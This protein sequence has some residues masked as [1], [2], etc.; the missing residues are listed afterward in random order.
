MS[1]RERFRRW[2][3]QWRRKRAA[4][5]QEAAPL[6]EFVYLDEVS[7][8]SL[9][10]S[11]LGSVA[12]EFTATDS[13]S[14]TGELTGTTGVS[15]GL[16]KSAIKSRSEATQTQGTQ[17]LRKATVQATFKELYEYLESG[18]ALRPATEAPPDV[19]DARDLETALE[20]SR[21]DGWARPANDLPRG[22]LVEIEVELEAEDIF[23]VGAV[24][25]T[26]LELFR[27][28]PE[29]LDPDVQ[30]QLREAR[31]MNALLNKLLVDLVPVRGR[32]IDYMTIKAT[33]QEWVV[34]RKVLRQLR[35]GWATQ[36][37]ALDV[38]AVAEASLFW[39]DIRRVLF[40]GSR[41]SLLCRIGRDG[42]H[43]DWTPVKLVDVVRE[44]VPEVAA[45]I[46]GAGRD[47]IA[48]ANRSRAAA[49]QS[50]DSQAKMREALQLYG[51]ALAAQH[52]EEWDPSLITADIFPADRT[53]TWAT[54]EEQRPPFEALTHQ[55]RQTFGIDP[56]RELIATLRHQ[57]LVQAGLVPF[58]GPVAG[59]DKAVPVPQPVEPRSRILDTELIAIY[60]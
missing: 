51:L 33:D 16:L 2:R 13:S 50:Q 28:A 6:R 44:F 30:E 14:L 21:T 47:L 53:H 58:T 41:Y 1:P 20:R 12:T 24:F 45:Q 18:F 35:E 27:E 19:R 11:R 56:D 3:G 22:E 10:S 37:Q 8:F 31:T 46:G 55:L 36:A 38:V 52:D 43:D 40:A 49:S 57:A 15:A 26:F 32:A 39:K 60:W 5:R 29:L 54:V 48:A 9:T 17:V 34:H 4:R 25:G 42:L 7:V 23:R 59:Q